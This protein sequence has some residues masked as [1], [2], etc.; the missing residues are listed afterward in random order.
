LVL[1]FIAKAQ[2]LGRVGERLTVAWLRLR[3]FRILAT[4]WRACGGELDIVAMR[5]SRL[6]IVEVKTRRDARFSPRM[7]VTQRKQ[8]CLVKATRDFMAKRRPSVERIQFDVV[9]VCWWGW[10][11]RIRYL[12]NAFQPHETKSGFGPSL[13]DGF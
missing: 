5:W 10:I 3:G 11:P 13:R 4:N 2:S 7:A 12:W 8:R 9:E 6:H 1:S